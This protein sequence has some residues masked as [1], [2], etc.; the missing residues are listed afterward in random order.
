M[1]DLE[2]ARELLRQA[3]ETQGRDFVYCMAGQGCF[4]TPVTDE[5]TDHRKNPI[6]AKPDDPRRLTGCIVGVALD[7]AG[8]NFHHGHMFGIRNLASKFSDKISNKAALYLQEAQHA[9][10][11]GATWGQAFDAAERS[12]SEYINR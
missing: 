3:V 7:L 12:L 2:R 6:N 9:Q 5:T 1:I 11:S 4:Y 8:E 10:D